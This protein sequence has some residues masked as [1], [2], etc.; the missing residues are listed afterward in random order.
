VLNQTDFL[1]FVSKGTFDGKNIPKD[2]SFVIFDL[3]DEVRADVV[4]WLDEFCIPQYRY[5]YEENKLVVVLAVKLQDCSLEDIIAE[6]RT[7]LQHKHP[8]LSV[9]FWKDRHYVKE[10][11]ET[12]FRLDNNPFLVLSEFS[13]PK[14]KPL[15]EKNEGWCTT[16]RKE[17]KV[18]ARPR[19]NATTVCMHHL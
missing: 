15:P 18:K 16:E 12:F 1:G 5:L 11:K 19:I 4:A 6:C 10:E 17:Y 2:H 13:G 7:D 9:L 3:N 8:Q 14:P